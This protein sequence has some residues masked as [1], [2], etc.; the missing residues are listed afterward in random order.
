MVRYPCM[1]PRHMM[2]TKAQHTRG[3]ISRDEPD[4]ALV[5]A[6]DGVAWIGEW[7]IGYRFSGVRFPKETTRELTDDEVKKYEAI[8]VQIAS[9]PPFKITIKR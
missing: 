1:S 5:Y 6:D 9:Q 7:V 3:D 2:A 4:L 8:S